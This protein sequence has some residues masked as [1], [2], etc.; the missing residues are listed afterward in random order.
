MTTTTIALIIITMS[1]ILIIHKVKVISAG[2]IKLFPKS[3]AGRLVVGQWDIESICGS[4]SR[5]G[6]SSL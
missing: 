6:A 1:I 3:G 4:Y 2:Q 5:F